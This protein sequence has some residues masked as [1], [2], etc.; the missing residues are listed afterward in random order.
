MGK[1][2]TIVDLLHDLYKSHGILPAP[3][4]LILLETHHLQV[5]QEKGRWAQKSSRQRNADV[6]AIERAVRTVETYSE[7]FTGR[8]EQQRE[9]LNYLRELQRQIQFI[10]QKKTPQVDMRFAAQTLRWFFRAVAGHP[11]DDAIG[12]LMLYAFRWFHNFVKK[13]KDNDN[14]RLAVLQRAKGPSINATKIAL[15]EAFDLQMQNY[16]YWQ[17]YLA[18]DSGKE[19]AKASAEGEELFLS[20]VDKQRKQFPLGHAFEKAEETKHVAALKKPS[21]VLG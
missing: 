7:V 15:R 1:N 8:I 3:V 20:L 9:A 6:T 17:E 13:D 12:S 14:A 2:P 21:S 16:T 10:K 18:T 11:L 19:A 5:M 4:L